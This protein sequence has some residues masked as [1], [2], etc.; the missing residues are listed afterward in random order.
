MEI[1]PFER[2]R[3]EFVFSYS[4]LIF[5]LRVNESLIFCIAFHHQS[6]NQKISI[7]I[8]KPN[9]KYLNDSAFPV[10]PS[11]ISSVKRILTFL[12]GIVLRRW[13]AERIDGGSWKNWTREIFSILSWI[14]HSMFFRPLVF[15]HI[16][17]IKEDIFISKYTFYITLDQITT[18][19]MFEL[20]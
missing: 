15:P 4:I 11:F 1:F 13:S 12:S 17:F 3:I 6:F 20:H 8:W 5:F 18:T 16:T 7:I 2:D 10:Y 19:A 9:G 14:F